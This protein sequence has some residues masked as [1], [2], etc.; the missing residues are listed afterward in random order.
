MTR[1]MG[2]GAHA[3]LRRRQQAP[4]DT[5]AHGEAG[6][7]GGAQRIRYIRGG[8]VEHRRRHIGL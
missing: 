2:N 7:G 4:W 1:P 3:G 6:R 8:G 5:V